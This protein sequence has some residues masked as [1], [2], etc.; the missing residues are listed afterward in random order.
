MTMG[1]SIC[2]SSFLFTRL[3]SLCHT[4]PCETVG[5]ISKGGSKISVSGGLAIQQIDGFL[6]ADSC[7]DSIEATILCQTCAYRF[8]CLFRLSRQRFHLTIHL[9][10]ADVDLLFIGH[11]LQQQRCL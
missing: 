7:P 3:R 9:F 5:C 2:R 6:V 8:R 4:P 11:F 10:V 1:T